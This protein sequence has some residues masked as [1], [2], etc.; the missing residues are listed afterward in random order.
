MSRRYETALPASSWFVLTM[1][2]SGITRQSGHS[3]SF[4]RTRTQLAFLS[5]SLQA[6]I[7]AGTLPTDV[8]LTRI[9][10]KPIP[11]DWAE[12]EHLYGLPAA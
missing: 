10:A 7:L 6:A 5:P 11:L 8:T 2:I 1:P 9:L 12:Q 4:I 3:E